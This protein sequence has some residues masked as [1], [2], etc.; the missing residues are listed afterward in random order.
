[1]FAFGP[2]LARLFSPKTL[3]VLGTKLGSFTTASSA[4]VARVAARFG[5][6]GAKA[7]AQSLMAAAKNNKFMTAVMLYEMY[8]IADDGLQM[9]FAEDPSLKSTIEALAFEADKVEDTESVSDIS[10][11]KEEFSYITEAS[12]MLGGFNR[13]LALRNALSLDPSTYKLYR[14]VQDLKNTL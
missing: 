13:L 5:Y 6:S 10:K 12:S 8:G 2:A 11:F 3:Q 14:S 7:T 9:M 1:M 4:V